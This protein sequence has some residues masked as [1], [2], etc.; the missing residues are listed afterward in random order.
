MMNKYFIDFKVTKE[1]TSKKKAE[2]DYQVTEPPFYHSRKSKEASAPND[3][4]TN[5]GCY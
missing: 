4:G 5:P 2:V 3:E 1:R